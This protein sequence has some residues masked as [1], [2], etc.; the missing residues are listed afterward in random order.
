MG[1]ACAEITRVY[2]NAPYTTKPFPFLC[3]VLHSSRF[4]YKPASV[5][6]SILLIVFLVFLSIYPK[7]KVNM[8]ARTGEFCYCHFTSEVPCIL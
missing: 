6:A 8:Y 3:L 1:R 7:G 2:V 5:M 4:C